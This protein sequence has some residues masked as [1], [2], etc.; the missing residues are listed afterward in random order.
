MKT[1]IL[2]FLS[3]FLQSYAVSNNTN[4]GKDDVLFKT[5]LWTVQQVLDSVE[6]QA[7]KLDRNT[8]SKDYSEILNT[9][10]LRLDSLGYN[11]YFLMDSGTI[12]GSL[13]YSLILKT[14]FGLGKESYVYF[15]VKDMSN[16]FLDKKLI[17]KNVSGWCYGSYTY[18]VL[19]HDLSSILRTDSMRGGCSKTSQYGTIYRTPKVDTVVFDT[20]T[21][22][23]VR[24]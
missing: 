21:K 9:A 2:I 13:R 11:K 15:V 14:V 5:D 18:G 6:K 19:K 22:K 4:R 20:I 16:N 17:A 12:D 3:L 23:F 24:K 1:L 8:Y 7:K 10:D